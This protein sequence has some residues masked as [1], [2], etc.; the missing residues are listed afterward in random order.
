MILH[1][2]L[3]PEVMDSD[4]VAQAYET[5]DHTGPNTAVVNRLVEL[6][7]SGLMLDLGTG[8]GHIPIAVC[9]R[10]TTARVVAVDLSPKMLA[11]ANG[12]L[13]TSPHA[14]R[15]IFR[16]ADVKSLPFESQSFD[17]VYSNTTLH[18][19]PD[20]IPMLREA[21]RVLRPRG[22]LLIRDLYRPATR[23]RLDELVALYAS[24]NTPLQRR[25][26]AD[27][28]HAAL[29]PSELLDA[30]HAAGMEYVTVKTDSDRHMTLQRIQ[31]QGNRI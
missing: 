6:G 23:N 27:S 31:K 21:W 24:D 19:L 4:E 2:A 5:M 17:V 26:L 3:E 22:V 13:L 8:P 1:R 11:I 9:E 29:N 25:L 7:A 18:H 10:L 20:P 30:A 15:I 12:H 14:N 28:L 16:E